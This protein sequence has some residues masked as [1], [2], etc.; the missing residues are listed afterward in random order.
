MKLGIKGLR[1]GLRNMYNEKSLFYI[2][3]IFAG[4]GG[5][6]CG[7]CVSLGTVDIVDVECVLVH[8]GI[9]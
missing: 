8:T 5:Q 9:L 7:A 3:L 1:G 4:G 2:H 6:T